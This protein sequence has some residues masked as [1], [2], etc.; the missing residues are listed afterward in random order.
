MEATLS[1]LDV[2]NSYPKDKLIDIFYTYGE[3][4][5]AKKIAEAIIEREEERRKYERQKN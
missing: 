4:H 5:N 2:V 3:E 1:A